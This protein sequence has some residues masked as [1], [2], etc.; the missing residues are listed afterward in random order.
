MITTRAVPA[1]LPAHHRR[2][3]TSPVSTRNDFADP[4]DRATT[5]PQDDL[6]RAPALEADHAASH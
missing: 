3:A 2:V 1:L 5:P 6:I 4:L